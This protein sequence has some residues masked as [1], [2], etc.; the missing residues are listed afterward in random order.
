MT[1]FQSPRFIHW[2][3]K[4]LFAKR[5]L[6]LFIFFSITVLLA[7]STT[8]LKVDA[9]FSKLLPLK[10]EYM[11][12][13]MQYRD[14]FGGANRIVVA[15]TVEQG[16]IFNAD[17]LKVLKQVT[18]EV[19]F[20]PGV[21]RSR[22]SSLFTPNV[23]FTEVV[24]SGIAG[25]TIVPADFIADARGIEKVK[26]NVLKSDYIGRLVANDFT[27]A[28]VSASLLE[29]N[30]SSGEKLDYT[31]VADLLEQ[32]IRQKFNGISIQQGDIKTQVNVHIIGF[33][34]IIGDIHKGASHVGLFFLIAFVLTCLLVYFYTQSL[35]LT[36]YIILA[37]S[38]SVIWLMGLLPIMGFGIDPMSI[39]V[40]FLIF[41][42]AVSH[43]M[44]MVSAV[45]EEIF[46]NQSAEQAARASFRRLLIPGGI[47]LLSDTVG[48]LTIWFIEIEVIREMAMT[49]SIGV[50]VIIVVNL[51][52]LPIMLSYTRA[53]EDYRQRLYHRAEKLQ[54]FWRALANITQRQTALVVIVIAIMLAAISWWQ[55]KD[56]RIGDQHAGVP[57]FH[58]D[59]RYNRDSQ[60]I[61]ER[62]S[63]GVDV[64]SVYAET[65][66]DGCIEHAL[67][68]DIDE[69]GWA[70]RNV[71]GVQ[72]V[73]SLA[74]V[75]KKINAGWN[76]GNLAWQ[77][78]PRN[79]HALVQATA[80]VPTS[81]GLLN[82]DCSVMPVLIFTQDHRQETIQR[83]VDAVNHYNQTQAHADI[84]Y[85]LAGSNVGVMAATNE[86]VEAAQFP[87]LL[88]VY[89][90]IIGLCLITFRSIIAV[91]CIIIPLA[92]V[93]LMSYALM[94]WLEIGLKV[95]T[96]P[97]VALGVGIGVDYGIY[98]Y[99]RLQQYMQ[100]GMSF[101]QSF[102]TTLS[103]TGSSVVFTA[104][105]LA[106]GV[107]TWTFSDLKFQADMG[108]LLTFMFILNMLG[109][110]LL[111]PALA[112][113][114]FGEE[115]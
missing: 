87:I 48:F 89:A 100:H 77:A 1:E 78:L 19:F 24:E 13:F 108:I 20:L 16:D 36:G 82:K 46:L 98:I 79:Q 9:G 69:F 80:H 107:L 71:D 38:G 99:S 29:V 28:L 94:A 74:S 73:I 23:R 14:E 15:L 6:M 55:G 67:L 96:L 3:E 7:L 70:I 88:Y 72:S 84:N 114:L 22:V 42:I 26:S 68:N 34:Q 109:A 47:A 60:I 2:L 56:I 65:R 112:A 4:V 52:F 58:Q 21:D 5:Q 12:P 106:S 8:Q 27:G 103:V 33:A 11:Q 64:I 43:G 76:E 105:I 97:V 54:Y 35:Q 66:K 81:T 51:I 53:G 115:S 101:H 25:G 86:I 62:F 91:F 45:R 102:Q 92:L 18:D 104:L 85:V 44:Q 83:V 61:T 49:A 113:W 31:K 90:V 59:S 37:A 17:F 93:S 39:L 111:L 30:A 50:A 32:R 40:P 41:A 57:E 63:I 75:A 110:V 95:N 10:H